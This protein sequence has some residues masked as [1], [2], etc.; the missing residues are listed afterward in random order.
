MSDKKLSPEDLKA[1][2]AAKAT[3]R[4]L[5]GEPPPPDPSFGP[6]VLRRY[7]VLLDGVTW[8]EKTKVYLDNTTRAMVHDPKA[9]R[10]REVTIDRAVV[11]AYNEADAWQ[12]FCKSWG[13][14]NS[15]HTPQFVEV[16]TLTEDERKAPPAGVIEPN[17]DVLVGVPPPRV[18]PI[19]ADGAF[20][21]PVPSPNVAAG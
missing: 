19:R 20:N 13:I 17:A 7:R 6:P 4:R 15:D 14:R 2:D 16:R 12:K 21:Q 5:E 18:L 11:E 9:G 10:A 1:L 3:I 8:V